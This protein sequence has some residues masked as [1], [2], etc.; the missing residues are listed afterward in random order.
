MVLELRLEDLELGARLG[1]GVSRSL[2][3]TTPT[4]G[5]IRSQIDRGDPAITLAVDRPLVMT[6]A[7]RG[8][9]RRH[10][11]T[12]R[13]RAYFIWLSGWLSEPYSRCPA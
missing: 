5:R 1:P 2:A 11:D 9:V 13:A 12:S 10:A 6:P 7:P 4:R 3:P 8:P